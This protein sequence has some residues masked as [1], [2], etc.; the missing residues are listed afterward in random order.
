MTDESPAP[1]IVKALEQTE[2]PASE[3]AVVTPIAGAAAV[4]APVVVAA[5]RVLSPPEGGA[6]MKMLVNPQAK[7]KG[8]TKSG[9]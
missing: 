9:K 1:K 6:V 2:T 5:P 4:V 8:K 7:S 3:S